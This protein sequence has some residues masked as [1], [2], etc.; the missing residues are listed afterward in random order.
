MFF[1]W[2]DVWLGDQDLSLPQQASQSFGC[3]VG[4]YAVV[5]ICWITL[6]RVDEFAGGSTVELADRYKLRMIQRMN[7][8]N[9][10]RYCKQ[11]KVQACG[12]VPARA[13][14]DGK[15]CRPDGKV[16]DP[17]GRVCGPQRE[18]EPSSMNGL[19]VLGLLSGVRTPV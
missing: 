9:Y 5:R 14:P 16:C 13:P 6:G 1:G 10:M 4:W 11:C 12:E 7:L 19:C 18:C 3:R 8:L 2:C 17:D 15:V